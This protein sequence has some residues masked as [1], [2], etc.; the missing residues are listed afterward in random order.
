MRVLW[1]GVFLPLR[2]YNQIFVVNR[3]LSSCSSCSGCISDISHSLPVFVLRTQPMFVLF[4]MV[5]IDLCA[6]MTL[7][8]FPLAGVPCDGGDEESDPS[9]PKFHQRGKSHT[10]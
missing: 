3:Q 2:A 7:D 6:L 10:L 4:V 5:L 1:L 9:T 8:L